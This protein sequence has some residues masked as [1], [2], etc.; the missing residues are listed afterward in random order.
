MAVGA[1]IQKRFRRCAKVR[2]MTQRHRIETFTL[3]CGFAGENLAWSQQSRLEDFMRGPAQAVIAEVFERACD[4]DE[5]WRIDRLELDLGF[6]RAD[7][8]DEDWALRLQNRLEEYLRQLAHTRLGAVTESAGS[9][10]E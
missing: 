2:A 6:L 8:S 5:V 10:A 9:A 7:Q 4:P 3:E 1:P